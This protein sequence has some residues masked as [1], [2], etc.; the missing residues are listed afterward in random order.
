MEIDQGRAVL[1]REHL[2]KASLP[3][4]VDFLFSYNVLEHVEDLGG[5][6]HARLKILEPNGVMVHKFDLTSRGLIENPIS[7]L[8]FKIYPDRVYTFMHAE[9]S[10]PTRRPLSAYI[11]QA[12]NK[13]LQ[14]IKAECVKKA[15]AEYTG[16]V[17]PRLSSAVRL[18]PDDSIAQPD[19]ILLA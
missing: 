12:E 14:D 17:L 16:V 8:D 13:G 18:E 2:E 11:H 3:E 4:P 5:F 10:R 7:L 1:I 19:L 9:R 15:S 6:F